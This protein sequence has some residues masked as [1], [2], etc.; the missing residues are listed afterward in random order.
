MSQ[1]PSPIPVP[2]TLHLSTHP[3]PRLA[4]GLGT[5]MTWAPSHTHPLPTNSLPEIRAALA[6]GIRHFDCGD[7]YTNMGSMA[8]A[9]RQAN[10]P[11]AD[12]CISLKL[13]TYNALKPA[14]RADMLASAKQVI[15]DLDLGGYV[16]VALLHFPPRGKGGNLT[17][18][19]AW[20]VLEE[21]RELG[22]ARVVG[23]SNW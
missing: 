16:D 22:M 8:T 11:R 21:L 9:L 6:A 17:N 1:P 23:V 2:A 7:L 5:L 19:E 20:G 18:R 4:F 10:L 3:I 13:N 15:A 14:S 12:L